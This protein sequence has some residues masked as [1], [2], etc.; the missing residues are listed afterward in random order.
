MSLPDRAAV[1]RRG[2]PTRLLPPPAA[3]R[4]GQVLLGLT[5]YGISLAMIV[6]ADLGLDPWDVF[7]QGVARTVDVRLG[8]VV[9]AVSIAVLLLWI[10]IRQRPGLGTILNAV[11]VGTVFELAA[12]LLP[13]DLESIVARGALLA[14]GIV[15]NA[16]ATAMYIG[17]GLGPGP[18]DGLMTG[19]ARRGWPIGRVRTGIEVTVLATGWLLGGSVGVGTVL[20]AVSIG[21]LV[22]PL[23]PL[24]S[25][26]RATAARPAAQPIASRRAAWGRTRGWSSSSS[27][28]VNQPGSSTGS[29]TSTR[30]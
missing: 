6:R 29:S 14:A 24:A 18:R 5:L 27:A 9:I 3:R 20:Y 26:D 28:T 23:L 13:D 12:P 16:V 2:D 17:A 19:L 15:L 7:H 22:Q 25:I 4:V 10:P 30:P 1:D 21:P 11:L 8:L